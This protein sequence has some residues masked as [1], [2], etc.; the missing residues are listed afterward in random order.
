MLCGLAAARLKVTP[1]IWKR[2]TD[3]AKKRHGIRA[4]TSPSASVGILDM[5]SLKGTGQNSWA[6][7]LD[8]LG[9]DYFAS[10]GEYHRDHADMDPAL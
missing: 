10:A 4:A 3:A 9:R 8:R 1:G 6:I 2:A 7:A 5:G